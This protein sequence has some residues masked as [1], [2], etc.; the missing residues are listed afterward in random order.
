MFGNLALSILQKCF[1]W[2]DILLF[3]IQD[4]D[5]VER[6]RNFPFFK[7]FLHNKQIHVIL[8]RLTIDVNVSVFSWIR[9][10]MYKLS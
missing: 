1:D 4:I 2:C 6:E 3:N 8:I 5:A 9:K 7:E 10:I